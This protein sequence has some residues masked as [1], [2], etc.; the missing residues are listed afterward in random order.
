MILNCS[1]DSFCTKEMVGNIRQNKGSEQY[2]KTVTSMTL[3]RLKMR[4]LVFT[5]FFSDLT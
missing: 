1:P 2:W 4:P 5:R 3:I